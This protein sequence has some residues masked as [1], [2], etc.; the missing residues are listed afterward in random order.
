MLGILGSDLTSGRAIRHLQ[1]CIIPQA[2]S[3]TAVLVSGD[4]GVSPYSFEVGQKEKRAGELS[5]PLRPC[6]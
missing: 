6:G 2:V 3:T 1:Y 5:Q 4:C